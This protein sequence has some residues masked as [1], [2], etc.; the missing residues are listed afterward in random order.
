MTKITDNK[1]NMVSGGYMDETADDSQAL[2]Y[3]GLMNE[4]FFFTDML[5][6]WCKYSAKVDKGWAKAGIRSVTHP[7]SYNEYYYNGNKITRKDAMKIIGV[8]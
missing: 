5:F 2:Y 7:A 8:I 6:H 4:Q 3:V 1:L